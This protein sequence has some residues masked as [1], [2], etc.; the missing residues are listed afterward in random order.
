MAAMPRLETI[1]TIG[2]YAQ[3]WHRARLGL[4]PSPP[5]G[6]TQLVRSTREG[7][8][9]TPKVIALPHP[10]WRNNGWLKRNPWFEAEVLPM[11]RA[12]VARLM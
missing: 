11:L 4:P 3:T 8:L 2:I 5:G 9:S 6:M 1:L 12:E 10:S 7:L